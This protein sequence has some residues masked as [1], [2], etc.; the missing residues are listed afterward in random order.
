MSSKPF[1]LLYFPDVESGSEDTVPM[2]SNVPPTVSVRVISGQSILQVND[3]DQ[4]DVQAIVESL[5]LIHPR[6]YTSSTL[7]GTNNVC[8]VSVSGMT[9][10]SC[11]KLIEDSLPKQCVGVKGVRVSLKRSEGLV[12]FDP[13]KT[14]LSEITSSIYD[15]G[16]D[17]NEKITFTST[18]TGTP[19]SNSSPLMTSPT[20]QDHDT[21]VI[22]IT[23]MVCQSCVNNI[24][25]N[26]GL[27]P[28]ILD[29]QVLLEKSSAT[30]SYKPSVTSLN[31]VCSMI[32]DLGF[33]AVPSG[34][35]VETNKEKSVV[36]YHIGIEGMTCQSCVSLIEDVTKK[37]EGVVSMVVS[38]PNK[39][40]T[41]E[42]H[43]TVISIDQIKQ[44]IED[45]GFEVTY[46]NAETSLSCA[47]RERKSCSPSVLLKQ[48]ERTDTSVQVKG[49][50]KKVC[51]LMN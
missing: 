22:Q 11:V 14:N 19:S 34:G 37:R 12:E 18:P 31:N 40:G 39:E 42:F 27:K 16:F 23:G 49:N 4:T 17:A 15:M 44:D 8:L 50:D 41:V 30:V 36:S 13:V 6:L 9:C 28:G 1:R 33:I 29:V 5:V 25:S 45:T 10:N 47:E 3:C 35:V 21:A 32:D 26:L 2:P 43:P 48:G 24:E 38:L 7:N 51:G 20:H 46:V